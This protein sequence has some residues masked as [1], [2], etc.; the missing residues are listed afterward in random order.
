MKAARQNQKS[1]YYV[2]LIV[3]GATGRKMKSWKPL[4]T[5]LLHPQISEGGIHKGNLEQSLKKKRL[6]PA[7]QEAGPQKNKV[8]D[9]YRDAIQSNKHD[10][11]CLPVTGDTT[12]QAPPQ[13]G[14]KNSV[15]FILLRLSHHQPF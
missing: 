9:S 14:A 5:G 15:M 8:S 7:R 6:Q 13:Q 10:F 12:P 1:F 3:L 2:K 11:L 4:E